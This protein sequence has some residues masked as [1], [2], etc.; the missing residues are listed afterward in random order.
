M[1]QTPC[2]GLAVRAA[3]VPRRA[4]RAV[5][6]AGYSP[7]FV[8]FHVVPD[9]V[10]PPAEWYVALTALALLAFLFLWLVM[11]SQARSLRTYS[12]R[13]LAV[14]LS[15]RWIARVLLAQAAVVVGTGAVAALLAGGL[16]IAIFA[17]STRGVLLDVP[18]GIITAA[19]GLF[20]VAAAASTV[21]ALAT[22][23]ATQTQQTW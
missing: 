17:A 12:A 1:G 18:V 14:G 15:R 5:T 21:S 7:D 11:R 23:R 20:V 9:H 22:L 10:D 3:L 6:A 19:T 13:L 2:V 8:R 16:P 4:V